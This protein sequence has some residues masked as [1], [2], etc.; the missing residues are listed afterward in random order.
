M[1]DLACDTGMESR[2]FKDMNVFDILDIILG[3]RAGRGAI[4]AGWRFDIAES[5]VHP[6]RSLTTQYRE[7]DL[8]FAE[9]LMQEEGLFYYF[10][11]GSEPSG[12]SRSG[13]IMVI[14]DCMPVEVLEIVARRTTCRVNHIHDEEHH[15]EP[16]R[17]PKTA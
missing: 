2:V 3:S 1:L 10:E 9:R 7:S 15:H 17:Y 4:A 12:I 16:I 6:K 14:A 13:R 11:H 5:A 8:A